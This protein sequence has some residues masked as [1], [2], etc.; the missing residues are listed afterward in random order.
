MQAP[1]QLI[2]SRGKYKQTDGNIISSVV[3]QNGHYVAF[4]TADGDLWL[5]ERKNIQQA[6]L[7]QKIQPHEGGIL[8][9]SQ[10]ITPSGFITAGDDN[11]IVQIIPGKE[12]ELLVKTKRWVEHMVTWF[13]KEGSSSKVAFV[14]GKQV[15]IYQDHFNKPLCVL[16]HDS[17]VSDLTFSKDGQNLATSYYNGAT[18]WA[19]KD[20]KADKI[21]D[22]VWKGSHLVIALHPKEEAIVTSMQDHDLHGWRISDAHNMRMSGYPVKVQS[23]NFSNDGKWLA[24]SGAE[25]VVMWP[26]FDGGPMGKPPTELPGIPGGYC[27]IV[28]FHPV[29][30]DL[31]AAGFIDGSILLI[32][33]DGEKVLPITL[34][35]DKDFGSITALNFDMA[36]SLLFFGTE[37][38]VIGLVDLSASNE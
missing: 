37:K 11:Q 5:V 31:L 20:Q 3:S 38:G 35:Q 27:T 2:D 13:D 15:H 7:W 25:S 26:F 4:A 8:C 17:T 12:P 18:L 9:L 34:G 16:E 1:I 33:P 19:I 14:E 29:Y 10:D 22:F 28:K 30:G 6:E 24:T 36:G 32:S 21:K 23:L